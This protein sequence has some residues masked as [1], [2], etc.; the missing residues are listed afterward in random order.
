MAGGRGGNVYRLFI[1]VYYKISVN[2]FEMFK[3]KKKFK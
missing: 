3:K 1:I 2:Y